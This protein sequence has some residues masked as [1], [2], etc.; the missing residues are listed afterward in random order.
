MPSVELQETSYGEEEL[1]SSINTAAATRHANG[2]LQVGQIHDDYH[3]NRQRSDMMLVKSVTES[4]TT[5]PV[6]ILMQ[7]EGEIGSLQLEGDNAAISTQANGSRQVRID[8]GAHKSEHRSDM[9]LA[10]SSSASGPLHILGNDVACTPSAFEDN[11][12]VEEIDPSESRLLV[13][14]RRGGQFRP[15]PTPVHSTY[16]IL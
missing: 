12:S 6:K 4:S 14:G 11:V 7:S 9:M 13:T 5:Q 2:A 16:H 8:D 15:W 3:Q 1:G 10:E